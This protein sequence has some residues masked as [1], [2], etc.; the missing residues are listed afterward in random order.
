[1][2]FLQESFP[3]FLRNLAEYGLIDLRKGFQGEF[4]S[5][6]RTTIRA[7]RPLVDLIVQSGVTIGGIGRDPEL[8]GDSI[9]LKSVRVDGRKARPLSIPDTPQVSAL[10]AQMLRVNR[11]LMEAWL[12]WAP[13]VG[14]HDSD[15]TTA[16]PDLGDRFMRR[17]FVQSFEGCG[18]LYGGFWQKPGVTKETRRSCL[19]IEGGD[20]VELDFGQVGVHIAYA[21]ARA[22]PL[23]GDQYEIPEL[24]DH[25]AGVKV[26]LSSLLSADKPLSRYPQGISRSLRSEMPAWKAVELLSRYHAP[27]AHL[28]C[29]SFYLTSQWLE[30][31]ILLRCID[32]LIEERISGIP[33]H[34][35]LL[36]SSDDAA[37]VKTI[38]EM[39]AFEVL[40]LPVPVSAS[41]AAGTFLPPTLLSLPTV[42]WAT[43]AGSLDQPLL[44][45]PMVSLSVPHKR[46]P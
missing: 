25:R 7:G 43:G 27:I 24:A 10:R 12:D 8:L 13:A 26:L 36:V 19:L 16:L 21:C 2:E 11:W 30:S 4:G 1:M 42:S 45:T 5:G 14:D 29:T 46:G 44:Y 40:G 17:L 33:N 18:R 22:T 41:T 37:R 31:L 28:F 23:P 38:M 3:D 15:D 6:R 20:V 34:D 9:G 39:S 35:C 32:H